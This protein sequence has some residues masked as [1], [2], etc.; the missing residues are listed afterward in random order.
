M[1][2]CKPKRCEKP[3]E[4]DYVKQHGKH[5]AWSSIPRSQG[6][7]AAIPAQLVDELLAALFPKPLPREE[8]MAQALKLLEELR[9]PG[10]GGCVACAEAAQ[11]RTVL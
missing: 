5:R 7:R 3:T 1:S 4:C 11:E 10:Q 6:Q 8:K 2:R 9:A